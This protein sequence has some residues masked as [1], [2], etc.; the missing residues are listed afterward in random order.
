MISESYLNKDKELTDLSEG[1]SKFRGPWRQRHTCGTLGDMFLHGADHVHTHTS[2]CHKDSLEHVYQ[3]AADSSFPTNALF[4]PVSYVCQK[5]P[6]P[7]NFGRLH[8]LLQK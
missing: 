6:G 4:T 8:D 2:C 5:N 7:N 1:H 3:S